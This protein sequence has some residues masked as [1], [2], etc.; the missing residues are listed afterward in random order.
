MCLRHI[1]N[2]LAGYYRIYKQTFITIQKGKKKKHL[3]ETN[4]NETGLGN[5]QTFFED[6]FVRM[7]HIMAKDEK[8]YPY[9]IYNRHMKMLKSI[10]P[11]VYEELCQIREP[12]EPEPPNLPVLIDMSKFF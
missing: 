4:N 3:M 8:E 9:H 5:P 6:I 1:L 7:G 11:R 12:V 10:N 2:S